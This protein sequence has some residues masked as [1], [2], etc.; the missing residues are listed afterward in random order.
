MSI[1]FEFANLYTEKASLRNFTRL[2]PLFKSGGKP[3][4]PKTK[5]RLLAKPYI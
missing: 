5:S 1:V 4:T 2:T 3:C